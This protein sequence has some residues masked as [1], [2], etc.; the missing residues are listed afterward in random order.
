MNK[1]VLQ[2][3]KITK[4]E[5]GTSITSQFPSM[6]LA[7]AASHISFNRSMSTLKLKPQKLD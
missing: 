4:K 5:N 3:S 2:E 1:T 6:Y 7:M